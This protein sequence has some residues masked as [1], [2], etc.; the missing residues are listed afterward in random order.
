MI[1][2]TFFFGAVA[3]GTLAQRR[4]PPPAPIFIVRAEPFE[5]SPRSDSGLSLVILLVVIAGAIW[6]L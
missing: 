4:G 3:L 2:I 6:V 1:G 5:R